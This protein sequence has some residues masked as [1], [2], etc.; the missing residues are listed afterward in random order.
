MNAQTDLSPLARVMAELDGVAMSTD[1]HEL[2]V[3][4]KDYHW[5]SPI[6]QQQLK[7]LRRW[8]LVTVGCGAG[9]ALVLSLLAFLLLR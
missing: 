6:L 8:T 7:D 9:G 2:D 4:S 1:A 3:K 5:Y